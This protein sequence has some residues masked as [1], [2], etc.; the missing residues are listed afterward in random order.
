MSFSGNLVFPTAEQ[1]LGAGVGR[2][3]VV[4]RGDDHRINIMY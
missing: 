3:N 1:D 2:E 4:G